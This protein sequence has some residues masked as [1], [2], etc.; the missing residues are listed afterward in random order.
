M[1]I[2]RILCPDRLR[3]VPK[4]FSWVDHSL[5]RDKHLCGR[6]NESLALYLFLVTVSDAD[7]LS[8]YSD[9][10]IARYLK[11]TPQRLSQFRIELCKAGFVAYSRPLYQVLSLRQSAGA[12]PEAPC[13]E[14]QSRRNDGD[15]L[16]IGAI[17]R[18]AFGGVQ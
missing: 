16:P 2:K 12:L 14:Q 1:V 18:Q 8:F 7:G 11:Q 15:L 13:E 6:S 9:A 4:Q 5:V 3:R 17:L 10:A